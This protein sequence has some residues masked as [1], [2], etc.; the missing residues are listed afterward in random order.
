MG[1]PR[2]PLVERAIDLLR[3]CTFLEEKIRLPPVGVKHT[4]AD[5]TVAHTDEHADFA[6]PLR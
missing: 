4:V 3:Q 6:E 5:K 2:L 1:S